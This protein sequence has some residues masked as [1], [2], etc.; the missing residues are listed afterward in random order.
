MEITAGERSYFSDICIEKCGGMCC[1]PWWGI[2]DFTVRKPGGL[3][4]LSS[5]R[6]ELERGIRSRSKRI[7]EGY[8]TN[9]A[10][11]RP[12]FTEPDVYNVR[13]RS[14]RA[15]GTTLIVELIAMYA[16]RC[17]FLS[18]DNVC[19]VHPS[20]LGG[21]DIRP[22]HCGFMGSPGVGP[23]EKG[24]CRVLHA[25]SI[26]AGGIETAEAAVEEALMV[27][28]GSSE[29]HYRRGF[30]SAGEATDAVIK[31]IRDFCEA[32]LPGLQ[33]ARSATKAGR[34]DPCPCGSGK[35]Y[36]KCHGR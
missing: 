24:Y 3:A 15:D 11:P 19:T 16:F 36:K 18:K 14:I 17:R 8:V 26:K 7:I 27:E 5:F 20:L 31:E 4:N 25:A 30:S 9:E 32:N 35:K 33:P 2:I 34:N 29:E 22:P 21:G 23:G 10:Q 13:V 1:D 28:K 6:G 12:L